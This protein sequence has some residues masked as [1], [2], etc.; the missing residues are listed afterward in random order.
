M[1][2]LEGF[3][4]KGQEHKVCKL[5]RSIYGLKQA[6]RS[7]NIRFDQAMKTY[8]FEQNIDEPCVYKKVKDK[9]G[10]GL[11]IGLIMLCYQ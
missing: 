10:Y 9:P 3:K 5:Q 2:Q 6:P 11:C 7:W 1:Q 8:R 4:A